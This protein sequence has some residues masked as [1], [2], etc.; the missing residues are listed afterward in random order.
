MSS[1]FS[2]SHISIKL[3]IIKVHL[4]NTDVDFYSVPP[5]GSG[6]I[7]AYI[8]N[9]LDEFNISTADPAPLLAHRLN[10]CTQTFSPCFLIFQT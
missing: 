5:P 4:S 1:E 8:L 3:F 6:A 9:I 7:L 10:S 2:S